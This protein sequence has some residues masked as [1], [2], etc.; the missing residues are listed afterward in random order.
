[1]SF[2]DTV[3]GGAALIEGAGL[4]RGFGRSPNLDNDFD[5]GVDCDG[6]GVRGLIR[7]LIGGKL[8]ALVFGVDLAPV[9]R[10]S[11][12]TFCGL[13]TACFKGV[14]PIGFGGPLVT[15]FAAL[16]GAGGGGSWIATPE[17]PDGLAGFS[18][19]A[20][21]AKGGFGRVGGTTLES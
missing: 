3:G 19:R 17:T 1:M 2:A 14:S 8:A 16:D 15:A 9:V 21:L 5:A 11:G 7:S 13:V 10:L 12:S 20:C 18:M 6:A 4:G